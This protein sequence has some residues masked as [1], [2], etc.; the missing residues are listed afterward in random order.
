[1]ARTKRLQLLLSEEEYE[2]LNAFAKSKQIPMSEVL[3]DYIKSLKKT[4]WEFVP[5]AHSPYIPIAKARGYKA[6]FGKQLASRVSKEIFTIFD[7]ILKFW[8]ELRELLAFSQSDTSQPSALAEIVGRIESMPLTTR[9]TTMKVNR[10]A[11]AVL[12]SSLLATS[13]GTTLVMPLITATPTQAQQMAE[14]S[15]TMMAMR[16]GN[17]VTVEQDHPTAGQAKIVTSNGKKYLEF[18]RAF[19]TAQGP[20]VQIVLYRGNSVPVKLAQKDYLTLAKLQKFDGAQRYEI[21]ANVNLDDFKAVGIWCKKLN[22][23]FGYAAL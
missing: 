7:R 17:F 16:S 12:F 11:S 5:Y 13:L 15:P 6:I 18:D 9:K 8:I 3:R 19:T 2:A 22:V 14:K 20:D 21:P 23:T 1:M 10:F 4:L